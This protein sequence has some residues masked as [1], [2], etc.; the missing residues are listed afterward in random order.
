ML[1]DGVLVIRVAPNLHVSRHAIY[2]L[3]PVTARLPPGTTPLRKVGTGAKK[4]ITARTD[5]LIRCNVMMYPSETAASSNKNI[6]NFPRR[7]LLIRTIR[8]R[9]QNDLNMPCLRAAKK[10]EMGR[11][12]YRVL[13]VSGSG[14]ISKYR[15]RQ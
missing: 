8:H 13:E 11:N 9:L 5:A 3:K 6:P 1:Q 12:R 4:K 7:C 14:S 10:L 15:Y 2:D